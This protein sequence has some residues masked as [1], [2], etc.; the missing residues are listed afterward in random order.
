VKSLLRNLAKQPYIW[1]YKFT[2]C[3]GLKFS[4]KT[5]MQSVIKPISEG[6]QSKMKVS[7]RSFA[8]GAGSNLAGCIDVC[9]LRMLCR[10]QLEAPETGRSP[11][12]GSPTVYVCH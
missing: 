2:L 9:L 10:V 4:T 5:G 8:G 6:A 3:N 11:V 7:G 12:Q 1:R